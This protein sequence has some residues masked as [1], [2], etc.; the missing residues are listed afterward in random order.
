MQYTI[1]PFGPLWTDGVFTVPTCVAD[2]YLKL[3]SAYQLQA[4][5]LLLRSIWKKTAGGRAAAAAQTAEEKKVRLRR[6]ILGGVLCGAA[7]CVAVNLQQAGIAAYP[8]GVAASGR[9]GFLTA[10]YVVFVALCSPLVGKKL[11]PIV[12]LSALGSMGGM[13]LLCLSRGFS[14]FYLGDGLELL[15]AAAF[16]VQILLV[17]RFSETD[18]VLLSCIQ[19]AVCGLI[20]AVPMLL[21]ESV[22]LSVLRAAWMPILYA[23]VMSGG[24][25]YTLQILGQ[26]TAPPALASI[27][28]SMESVFAALAG[29]V[30]L[31]E[32]LS[33]VELELLR[34]DPDDRDLC[35]QVLRQERQV[36][37]G[38][39]GDDQLVTGTCS[40]DL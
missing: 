30:I 15:C 40:R 17:D 23:G 28:M 19:F 14:S 29:W 18:G 21:F 11:H 12:L 22:S 5:L 20:S 25:G 4:L 37:T 35:S 13:Y 24:V 8:Q 16:T 31:G 27:L 36:H 38:C 26:K 33:A 6:T 34:H 7:L 1:P 2:R 3:A 39:H 32:R 9:S 10:M